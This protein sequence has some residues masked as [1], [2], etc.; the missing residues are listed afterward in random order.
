MATNSSRG[1]PIGARDGPNFDV[2]P[3]PVSEDVKSQVQQSSSSTNLNKAA[4]HAPGQEETPDNLPE[5]V[6][7]MKHEMENLGRSEVAKRG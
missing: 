2:S 6:A 3:P 5:P 1:N 7:D 4:E